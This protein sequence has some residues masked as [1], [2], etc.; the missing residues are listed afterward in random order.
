MLNSIPK[1]PQPHNEPVLG[2]GPGSPEKKALKRALE[3]MAKTPTDIPLYVGGERRKGT[4][5]ADVRSPWPS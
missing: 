1:V 2:Y 5:S 4:G 3:T